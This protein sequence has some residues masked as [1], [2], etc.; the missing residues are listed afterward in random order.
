MPAEYQRHGLQFTVLKFNEI[1]T[2]SWQMR[3]PDFVPE[4]MH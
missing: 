2:P 4:L 1:A 3:S